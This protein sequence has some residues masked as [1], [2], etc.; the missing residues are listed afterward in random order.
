MCGMNG[1]NNSHSPTTQEPKYKYDK[2]QHGQIE[3][4]SDVIRWL[5]N[6]R[7]VIWLA[8]TSIVITQFDG[9]HGGIGE[10]EGEEGH[11]K[12]ELH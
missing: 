8:E 12:Q 9:G 5:H 1:V 3:T 7:Y 11:C 10:Q 6:V 4:Q 2:N